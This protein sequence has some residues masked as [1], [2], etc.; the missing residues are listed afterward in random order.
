[1]PQTYLAAK[2][3]S[4]QLDSET[5]ARIEHLAEARHCSLHVV[6]QEAISQYVTRED[7]REAFNFDTVNAWND[8]Q[9]T[10]LHATA[11]DVKN[12]LA[13]WGSDNELS[14]PVCHR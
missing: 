6:M 14:A 11:A 4:V 7:N 9:Q 2:T 12:W 8:Y 1:M 3:V 5:H 10:G 13:S